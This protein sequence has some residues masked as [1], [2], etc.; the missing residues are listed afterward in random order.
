LIRW[1]FNEDENGKMVFDGVMP[2]A[3]GS[4]G[5]MWTN[6]RFSQPGVS[7]QQHSRHFSHEYEFPI[8][9]R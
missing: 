6:Y 4:G 2:Y 1:G 8:P 9:Y 7:Q 3:T 5:L